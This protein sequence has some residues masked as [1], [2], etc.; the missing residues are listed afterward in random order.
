LQTRSV[1]WN[2]SAFNTTLE[3]VRHFGKQ[4]GDVLVS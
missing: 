4:L 2:Y 3:H 1:F